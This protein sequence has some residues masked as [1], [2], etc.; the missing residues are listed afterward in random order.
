MDIYFL[1]HADAEEREPGKPDAIRALTPKGL[2]QSREV[3]QWA[4]GHKVAAQVVVT[5]PLVRARQTAEPVAEALGVP[6]VEDDRLGGGAL[7][8]RALMG[9]VADAGDPEGIVFVGHEPDLS[10]IIGELT[11]GKVALKKAA[12]ALVRCDRVEDL[13]GELVWLTTSAARK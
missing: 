13:C 12:L 3:A 5:S 2:D 9:I 6:L 11:G 4:A 10:E 7:T 1:R 8:L